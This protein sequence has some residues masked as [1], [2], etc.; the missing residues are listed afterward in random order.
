[1]ENIYVIQSNTSDIPRVINRIL[2]QIQIKNN[3]ADTEYIFS[4]KITLNELLT[5]SVIH[6]NACDESKK[7]TIN[8]TSNNKYIEFKITDQGRP[9]NGNYNEQE[10][11]ILKEN[12]RGI[13]ICKHYCKNLKYNFIEG[14]GNSVVIKFDK[15]TKKKPWHIKVSVIVLLC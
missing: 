2:N 7:V 4:I 13:I 15:N 1:M 5:N 14:I 3:I 9:F 11:D 8:V 6:G 10:V 12:N